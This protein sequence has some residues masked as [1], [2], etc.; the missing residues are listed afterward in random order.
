MPPWR[1]GSLSGSG[2]AGGLPPRRWQQCWAACCRLY[3][4]PV[5]L[6]A[7]RMPRLAHW[8]AWGLWGAAPRPGRARASSPGD[9][10]A[11]VP[12]PGATN[13]GRNAGSWLAASCVSPATRAG[14][15]GAASDVLSWRR[16]ERGVCVSAG[17]AR[18]SLRTR[19]IR[20]SPI[21]FT[22]VHAESSS[23]HTPHPILLLNPRARE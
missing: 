6:E 4:G 23:S 12:L 5:T 19:C 13:G 14:Q 7:C 15:R 17:I 22:P 2:A 1:S 21:T 10:E 8:A 3:R 16:W 20:A 11:R 9:E 18:N